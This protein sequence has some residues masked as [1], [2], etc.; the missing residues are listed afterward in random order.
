MNAR[1][2]N[3][4]AHVNKRDC[5]CRHRDNTCRLRRHRA[6]CPRPSNKRSRWPAASVAQ[7]SAGGGRARPDRLGV[8]EPSYGAR[9][10]SKEDGTHAGTRAPT[11]QG[12]GF[13]RRP[14]GDIDALFAHTR[15]LEASLKTE[16]PK[17][18]RCSPEPERC[19]AGTAAKVCAD[20]G[21]R[22][23]VPSPRGRPPPLRACVVRLLGA[24]VVADLETRSKTRGRAYPKPGS[25]EPERCTKEAMAPTVCVC[26]CVM[27]RSKAAEA[28]QDRQS[29]LRRINERPC[30]RFCAGFRAT[31]RRTSGPFSHAPFRAI[32]PHGS[33]HVLQR[34][35]R[36]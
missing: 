8:L 12:G 15:R 35:L 23:R 19:G 26:V 17:C 18:R 3:A 1:H 28:T 16:A 10:Q 5:M 29:R 34:A 31:P 9:G 25:A 21:H 27:R 6:E 30:R 7:P 13:Y 33:T 14:K 32:T 36:K 4:R 2:P 22:A 20:P 24:D 11:F